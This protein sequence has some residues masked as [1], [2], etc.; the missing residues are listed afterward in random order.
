MNILKRFFLRTISSSLSL[1]LII[2]LNHAYDADIAAQ[3]ISFVILIN[4]SVNVGRIGYDYEFI[5]MGATKE[6]VVN[7]YQVF[8]FQVL[9]STTVVLS[10]SFY[11]YDGVFSWKSII[12]L[13]CAVIGNHILL[14][15][16][17]YKLG[18]GNYIQSSFI[19]PIATIGVNLVACLLLPPQLL[20]I[21]IC[22]SP[23]LLCFVF[24]YSFK[25]SAVKKLVLSSNLQ[26]V[27]YSI[28]LSGVFTQFINGFPQY[29]S[30]MLLSAQEF[31]NFVFM[32]R[33][34]IFL[35]ATQGSINHAIAPL[36][37][38]SQ[39]DT[40]RLKVLI[41]SSIFILF[42][43]SIFYFLVLYLTSFYIDIFERI[44]VNYLWEFSTWIL[45]ALISN[46]FGP[47]QML[48]YKNKQYSEIVKLF[49]IIFILFGIFWLVISLYSNLPSIVLLIV[50]HCFLIFISAVTFFV[51]IQ[52][53]VL[54]F[55]KRF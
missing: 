24:F 45:V 7:L 12:G 53:G 36:V 15:I 13:V 17:L 34:V 55:L 39:Q 29:M 11:W 27:K 42:W 22:I 26:N 18:L 5:R 50:I 20:P 30:Y 10:A 54:S 21:Y 2:Y 28:V 38:K 35:K 31:I 51:Q 46:L 49:L 8:V 41:R 52:F 40:Q 16:S 33:L 1:L 3:I 43:I 9:G 44:R 6:V 32:F 14:N 23:L 25:W 47:N 48:M 37:F 19:F 4:L